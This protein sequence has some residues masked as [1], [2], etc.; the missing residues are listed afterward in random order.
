[1]IA[2]DV[3]KCTY[4]RMYEAVHNLLL[5]PRVASPMSSRFCAVPSLT[6]STS[7]SCPHLT[8]KFAPLKSS[9]LHSHCTLINGYP[10]L[11]VSFM[12]PT[13]TLH[14]THTCVPPHT[15]SIPIIPHTHHHPFSS[16]TPFH[17]CTHSEEPPQ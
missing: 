16:H 7:W 4:V 13:P 3:Y 15:F 11:S 8:T 12:H 10:T 9:T 17:M 14:N 5:I 6:E 1:M 2:W